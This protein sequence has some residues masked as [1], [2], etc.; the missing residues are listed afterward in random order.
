MTLHTGVELLLDSPEQLKALADP[1]R[2]KILRVLQDGPASAK[3]LSEMLDMT[4]GKVGHHVKVLRDAELIEVVETRS[5]R[6]LTE[7]FY[8]LTYERLIMD[9]RAGDRLQFLLA[10]AAREALPSSEQTFH[11]PGLFLTVR[12]SRSKAEEINRRLSELAEEVMASEQTDGE[13][14]GLVVSLFDTDT[15]TANRR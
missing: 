3:Q 1:T 5:V 4:H 15:P 13:P 9:E 12:L 10:Q 6:A 11:P 14:F 8:G 7:K 2:S